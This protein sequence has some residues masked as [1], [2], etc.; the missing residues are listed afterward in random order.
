LS[1]TAQVRWG[2]DGLDLTNATLRVR[3]S[4]DRVRDASGSYPIVPPKSRASKRDVPLS[5]EDA[6]AL[7]R[8]LLTSGR[9]A[10]GLVESGLAPIRERVTGANLVP[11]LRLVLRVGPARAGSVAR[12]AR[13]PLGM[14]RLNDAADRTLVRVHVIQSVVGTDRLGVCGRPGAVARTGKRNVRSA[15]GA[16]Y[17]TSESRACTYTGNGDRAHRSSKEGLRAHVLSPSEVD[18]RIG[19]SPRKLLR[20]CLDRR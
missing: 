19:V 5:P 14:G 3:R 11:L 20:R 13:R 2:P 12:I 15:R 7:G 1:F 8:H 9:P 18:A 10:D 16:L 4:L 17:L 6:A